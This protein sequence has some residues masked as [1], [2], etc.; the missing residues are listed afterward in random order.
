M[1]YL[2]TKPLTALSN[3]TRSFLYCSAMRSS[4]GSSGRGSTNRLRRASRTA[5]ILVLGF[6]FSVLSRPRQ[7]LPSESL[8][9]LGW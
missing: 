3:S 7:T 4:S 6:Q 8:V 1:A 9:T 2:S 5:T